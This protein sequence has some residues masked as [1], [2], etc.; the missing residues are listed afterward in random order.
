MNESEENRKWQASRGHI[1]FDSTEQQRAWAS[2]VEQCYKITNAM[3]LEASGMVKIKH[4][5]D[6][7]DPL[8][9]AIM[10]RFIELRLKG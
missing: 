2:T 7:G 8:A 9:Q 4:M 10:Q 3:K 5:A 1:V 6:D